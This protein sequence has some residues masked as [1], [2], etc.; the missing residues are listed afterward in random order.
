[1]SYHGS[2]GFKRGE[3]KATGVPIQSLGNWVNP[4]YDGARIDLM[5]ILFFDLAKHTVHGIAKKF[6]DFS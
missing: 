4:Y 2:N 6:D 5:V 1:M 3:R